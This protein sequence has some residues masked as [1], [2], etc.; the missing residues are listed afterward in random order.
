MTRVALALLLFALSPPLYAQ[1]AKPKA[2]QAN[3]DDMWVTSP[4]PALPTRVTHHT[5]HSASMQREVGYC[6]YLPPG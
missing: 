5:F 4:V 3:T 2:N 1:K 6:L